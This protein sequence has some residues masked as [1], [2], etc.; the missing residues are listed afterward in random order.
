MGFLFRACRAVLA[1]LLLS[2]VLAAPGSAGGERVTLAV[3]SNFKTVVDALAPAFEEASGHKVLVSFG[4]SGKLFTQISQGAPF[5]LLL[6]ADELRP[7]LLVEQGLALPDSRFTY[8]IGKLA[9]WSALSRYDEDDV[10]LDA[11]KD[12]DFRRLAIANPKLAPYGL[13]AEQSLTALGLWDGVKGRIVMGQNIGQTFAMV[14]TGNAELGLVALSFLLQ[15]EMEGE[16]R[17]WEV[18][19]DLHD[20]IRQD[21]VLLRRAEDNRAARAF[22]AYLQSDDARAIIRSFGYR[23]D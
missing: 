6:S 23:T 4:S 14:A 11:L 22:L 19:G 20:P 16:G 13:A 10:L 8:A 5:D 7:E 9:L 2:L 18:P 12:G 15:P 17:Y 3:A 1:T 21:A